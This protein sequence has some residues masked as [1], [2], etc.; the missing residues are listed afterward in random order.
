MK[1]IRVNRLM[2]FIF[3]MPDT[4]EFDVLDETPQSINKTKFIK[5]V[6][7]HLIPLLIETYVN[8]DILFEDSCLEIIEEYYFRHHFELSDDKE[9]FFKSILEHCKYAVCEIDYREPLVRYQGKVFDMFGC[10]YIGS[11]LVEVVIMTAGV[12]LDEFSE[13]TPDS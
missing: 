5:A 3:E 2:S 6:L 12:D 8:D 13:E 10:N 11:Y 4:L 1:L 9:S 7:D